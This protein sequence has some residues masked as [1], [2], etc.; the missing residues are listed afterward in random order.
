ML[1][2]LMTILM[3]LFTQFSI[4][5]ESPDRLDEKYLQLKEY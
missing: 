4:L 2:T 5:I 3:Q 1:A